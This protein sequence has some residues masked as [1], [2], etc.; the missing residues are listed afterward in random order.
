MLDYNGADCTP[1]NLGN[2]ETKDHM[3][4]SKA[5]LPLYSRNAQQ[6][7]ANYITP[8]IKFV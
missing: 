3:P 4:Q 8:Y 2:N 5:G 6:C 7:Q 1:P